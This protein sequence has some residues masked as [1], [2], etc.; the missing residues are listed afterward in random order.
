MQRTNKKN[1]TYM[2]MAFL[3]LSVTITPLS[4]KSIGLSPSLTA[5][6][7]A[8]RQ[9]SSVFGD[10][11]QPVT[12]SELLALNSL[13]SDDATTVDSSNGI[14]QSLIAELQA[15][16]K[17]DSNLQVSTV[18]L[19]AKETGNRQKRC[20]KSANQ[21][22]RAVK[23]VEIASVINHEVE[24]QSQTAVPAVRPM[25]V[26][27]KADWKNFEKHLSQYKFD[28]GDAM[29]LL[30][31]R[32][33]KVMIKLKGLSMPVA[34][35]APRCKTRKAPLPEQVK[36]LQQRA[37]RERAEDQVPTAPENCEL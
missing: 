30:P 22:L 21:S 36:Q 7:D 26:I 14:E 29:K 9:I 28:I 20:S 24:I 27:N 1:A 35:V 12:S 10:S 17:A 6:I 3:F 15:E 18:E 37:M 8:W 16:T 11:H 2:G 25:V 13:N 4:L 34:P 5:G 31:I 32:D 23:R 19:Q 33:S